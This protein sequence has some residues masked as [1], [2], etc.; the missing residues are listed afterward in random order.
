MIFSGNDTAHSK[1]SRVLEGKDSVNWGVQRNIL[2]GFAVALAVIFA[3]FVISYR[4][5]ENLIQTSQLVAERENLLI[6]L[7]KTLSAVKDIQSGQRGYALT[8]QG[9]MLEPYQM[10][11]DS[12]SESIP[13]L[14]TL[15]AGSPEE[16][17]RITVLEAA[18]RERIVT[19]ERIIELREAGEVEEVT[20]LIGSGEGNRQTETIRN[21][22]FAIEA[23]QRGL[24]RAMSEEARARTQTARI[25]TVFLN[26]L[27]MTLF[28]LTAA[29]FIRHIQSR[30]RAER[31]LIESEWRYR[32]L[33]ENA[34]DL[35]QSV[36]ASGRFRYVNP[37][38]RKA[39]GYSEK[40]IAQRSFLDVIH[41]A[42][43]DHCNE[44][45][46]RLIAGETVGRVEVLFVMKG[47][48]LLPAEGSLTCRFENGKPVATRG[49]F[50]DVR[51]RKRIEQEMQQAKDAAEAASR[52]KSDFLA[53][54]SHEIR[55][56]LNGIIGMTELTLGTP[57]T[58]EQ[59]EYL[60]MIRTSAD[61][62]RSV[63][64]DI[65]DFS[66]I[67]AGRLDFESVEFRLREC[68]G[69]L[70]KGLGFRAHE[71]KL[72]L[73]YE[74]PPKVPEHLVG[75]PTRLSQILVNLVGNAI[76]FTDRGEVVLHV[77]LETE[78]ET[79]ARLHFSV[80]DTGN[81][82]P[83]ERQAAI[84]EAFSQADASTTRRYGGTGLGLA[85]SSSLVEL[86]GGTIWVESELGRG[87]TF[88]FTVAVGVATRLLPERRAE[89]DRSLAGVRALIVDDNATNRHFLQELF[90]NWEMVPMAVPSGAAALAV[91]EQGGQT[92]SDF[93][94]LVTDVLMPDMDGFALLEKLR[95]NPKFASLPVVMLSS[96]GSQ[97]GARV[98]ELGVS[99]HLIK[100]A[101]QSELREAVTTALGKSRSAE[102]VPP[103]SDL[104]SPRP[105]P[106]LR[107]LLAEDN[108][109]NQKVATSVLEK[110]GHTVTVAA[111][112]REVLLACES[113]T[114]DLVLMDVQMPE[115]DG[116]DATRAIRE[117]EK[118]TGGRLPIIAMTAHAMTGDRERCLAA[119][120]DG[121][122]A[123]PLNPES[124][125]KAIEE[126]V[127]DPRE[128][129]LR[130]PAGRTGKAAWT[131]TRCCLMSVE[132]ANC[133]ARSPGCSSS[134]LPGRWLPC[135]IPSSAG[136]PRVWSFPPTR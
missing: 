14:R 29:V 26:L 118:Q 128:P 83:R 4:N 6:E 133:C 104:P 34:S 112:G 52:A 122:V 63:I 27:I 107:V 33:F 86:M 77:E 126:C 99:A 56:P 95:A 105:S 102:E 57:V 19:A 136:M 61:T 110:R 132:T 69:E 53:N 82:I 73:L 30:T 22:V 9:E 37:A 67:E 115:M 15:A 101:K 38:W 8:G 117:R 16:Q 11:R 51:E 64:N 7:E 131:E 66:K 96:A 21:I 43:H 46:R 111:T 18:I 120:M 50:R 94:L 28:V 68:V 45:F 125:W 1:Q 129:A 81:G 100:P 35:I 88:H 55:T 90:A 42:Y 114:F 41:P 113:G 85:I 119:G 124:L 25:T 71:K 32:D 12:I 49:I 75:D 24:L 91:L 93:D 58:S 89:R 20:G 10:G 130:S 62:L 31:D 103:A 23:E 98:Q 123:K 121:Y 116:L 135:E 2:A 70:M 87:S 97:R 109:I 106:P 79:E 17:R 65:L 134:R 80:T 72:E 92:E 84:F 3:T 127:P 59:R 76:K 60:S 44:L 36:S 5:T 39:L 13:T 74:I 48:D 78:T 108:A 40:E 47:G 54:M